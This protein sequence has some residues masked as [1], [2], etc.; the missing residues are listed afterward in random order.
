MISF[1]I[2]CLVATIV[3]LVLFSILLV[4]PANYV[5]GYG[6]PADSGAVFMGRRAAPMLLAIALITGLLRGSL[7][8]AVQWAVSWGM[9]LG[10]T[11]VAVTGVHAYFTGMAD[12]TILLAAG[13]EVLL[14]V[15]FALSL[16][17]PR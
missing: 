16:R 3:C 8:L 5:A 9:I 17:R 6:G 2:A 10:F 7:D 1:R 4:A 11:G 12:Q 13:G 15:A 14:A